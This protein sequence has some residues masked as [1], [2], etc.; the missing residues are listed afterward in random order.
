EEGLY[1]LQKAAKQG[2]TEAMYTVASLMLIG[3][4]SAENARNE[5]ICL[6]TQ[7]AA[8]DFLPAEELLRKMRSRQLEMLRMKKTA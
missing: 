1:W 4:I 2:H 8:K 7:S 6:L 3:K 5:A